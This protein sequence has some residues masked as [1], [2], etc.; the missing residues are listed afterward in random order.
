[1]KIKTKEFRI[2]EVEL[3]NINIYFHYRAII[4]SLIKLATFTVMSL[5]ASFYSPQ[6][7]VAAFC[8]IILISYLL[9]APFLIQPSKSMSYLHFLNRSCEITDDY[10][11]MVFEDGTT[12]M[13]TLK[14]YIKVNRELEYYFLYTK[15]SFHYL[16]ISSFNSEE[17]INKFETLM[18]NKKLMV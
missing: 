13:V 7:I 9:A 15:F 1:M 12:N 3:D 6:L 2:T 11:N 10:F 16:P 18:K 8:P 5:F 14:S 4:P 17:D